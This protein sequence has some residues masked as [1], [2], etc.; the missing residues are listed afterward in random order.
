VSSA[1]VQ[2]KPP[3]DEVTVYDVIG[4][5][6]AGAASHVSVAIPSPPTAVDSVG[7]PGS[8]AGVAERAFDGEP[9]PAEFVAVT[10]KE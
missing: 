3:G 2:V 5:P 1:V 4:E 7:A 10:V 8:A 6:F 9:G